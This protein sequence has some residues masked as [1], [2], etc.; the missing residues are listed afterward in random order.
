MKFL[1]IL[2]LISLQEIFNL[3]RLRFLYKQKL[4]KYL[5]NNK[6]KS[7]HNFLISKLESH[8]KKN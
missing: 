6:I 5:K 3:I 2:K 7:L 4:K 8:L 1:I